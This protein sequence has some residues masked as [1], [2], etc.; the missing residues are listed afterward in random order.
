MLLGIIVFK[1]CQ[2]KTRFLRYSKFSSIYI[3]IQQHNR[4]HLNFVN[5][6]KITPTLIDGEANKLHFLKKKGTFGLFFFFWKYSVNTPPTKPFTNQ[7]F[8]LFLELSQQNS[9]LQGN[10]PNE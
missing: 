6:C 3:S 2:D 8:E 5:D 7:T 1:I 9:F 4:V 10:P